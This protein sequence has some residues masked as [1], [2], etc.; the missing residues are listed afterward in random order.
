MWSL[1]IEGWQSLGTMTEGGGIQDSPVPIG[2]AASKQKDTA[3]VNRY[4]RAR[5][6]QNQFKQRDKQQGRWGR[7][8]GRMATDQ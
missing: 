6:R 8:P 2:A 7:E 1:L 3:A 5:L 4:A